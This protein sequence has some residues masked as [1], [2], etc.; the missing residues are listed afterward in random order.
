VS[1]FPAVWQNTTLCVTSLQRPLL[2]GRI[3]RSTGQNR[4][5]ETVSVSIS[6][7][8]RQFMTTRLTALFSTRTLSE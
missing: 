3:M 4:K 8:A 1:P 2:T 6:D 5:A 7:Y